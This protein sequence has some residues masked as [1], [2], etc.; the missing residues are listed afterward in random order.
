M[1][2]RNFFAI[3]FIFGLVKFGSITLDFNKIEN[4]LYMYIYIYTKAHKVKVEQKLL[5]IARFFDKTI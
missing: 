1:H 5:L 2:A 4:R 3:F